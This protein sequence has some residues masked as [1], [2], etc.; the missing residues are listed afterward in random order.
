MKALLRLELFGYGDT[1]R[2][3]PFKQRLRSSRRGEGRMMVDD[4]Q[5]RPHAWVREVMPD[6]STL[7]L[8]GEIDLMSATSGGRRGVFRAF[9]LESGKQYIVREQIDWNRYDEYRCTVND[10]G[11]IIR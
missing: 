2:H 1:V 11:D 3:T 6:G 10:E 7:D 4:M 8:R 9:I 5:G